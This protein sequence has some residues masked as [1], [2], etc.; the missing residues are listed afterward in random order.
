MHICC[1]LW[2]ST[3][4][5]L[6]II[7]LLQLQEKEAWLIL[8]VLL[9]VYG[10]TVRRCVYCLLPR[11]RRCKKWLVLQYKTENRWCAVRPVISLEH[12]GREKK[13]LMVARREFQFSNLT[14]FGGRYFRIPRHVLFA[15]FPFFYGQSYACIWLFR[16]TFFRTTCYWAFLF[17]TKEHT[18]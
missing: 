2:N 17:L 13:V 10:F 1:K 18:W 12:T 14:V 9:K 7:V 6:L 16:C 3:A 4:I 11:G 15:D 8:L 5:G